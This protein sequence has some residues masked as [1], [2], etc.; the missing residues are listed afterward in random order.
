MTGYHLAQVNIARVREPP[1][2]LSPS[3]LAA[4]LAIPAEAVTEQPGFVWSLAAAQPASALHTFRLGCAEQ[5]AAVVN[6]TVWES[7]E[8]LCSAVLRSDGSAFLRRRRDWFRPTDRSTN[9]LWWVLAGHRPDPAEA[10]DRVRHLRAHG[11]TATAF[12]LRLAFPPPSS[13][14]PSSPPSPPPAS[15]VG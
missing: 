8:A 5:L 3:E 11:A 2:P 13:P 15:A 14:Q 4:D 1:A 6:L 9:A 10:E 12:T 7:V